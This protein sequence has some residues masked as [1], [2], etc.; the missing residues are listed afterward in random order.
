M[1]DLIKDIFYLALVFL[2][3]WIVFYLY[4][5][6]DTVEQRVLRYDCRIAEFS[7]DIP[8]DVRIQCRRQ[9]LELY[10]QQRMKEK[11]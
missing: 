4:T 8:Q 6:H 11:D 10:N 5:R 9:A 1:N 3:V 2:A 7:P